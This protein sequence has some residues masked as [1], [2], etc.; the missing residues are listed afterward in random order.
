MRIENDDP[1]ENLEAHGFAR[2]QAAGGHTV[3]IFRGA[4][5]FLLVANDNAVTLA[6]HAGM[7]LE[8]AGAE[9]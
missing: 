9:V 7:S 8:A 6:S 1:E 5:L 4:Q 3:F 2:A